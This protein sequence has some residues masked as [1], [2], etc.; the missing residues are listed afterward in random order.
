M[1]T[2]MAKA[3]V[4]AAV[5][6]GLIS[7]AA[8]GGSEAVSSS[9]QSDAAAVCPAT[10][11]ETIGAACAVAGLHCGPRYT[12]GI[13]EAT[14]LCVCSGGTFHCTDGA[15]NPL[16]KGAAPGCPAP[17]RGGTCPSTERGAQLSSCGEQGLLCAYPSA[18]TGR[19]DQCQ[20]FPG[21][22]IDG[23]FGLRFECTPATC[24]GFDAGVIVFDAGNA[25][26]AVA[27]SPRVPDSGG[28]SEAASTT[29]SGADAS[30]DK[31][32]PT[33]DAPSE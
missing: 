27:D 33:G 14:L 19:F 29:D 26:D 21:P 31:D 22:T 13:T 32:A 15:G 8:C 20:C 10:P 17:A 4:G 5:F 28:D 30:S 16:D 7:A 25:V 23:G 9:A 2:R 12:C 24:G 11:S 18:C 6:A 1:R 3:A